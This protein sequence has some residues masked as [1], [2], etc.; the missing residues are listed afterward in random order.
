MGG[1][2]LQ[3]GW[4]KT[5]RLSTERTTNEGGGEVGHYSTE[6]KKINGKKKKEEEKKA[7]KRQLARDRL[8]QQSQLERE[9]LFQKCFER[10]DGRDECQL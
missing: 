3:D 9:R 1:E 2:P 5:L 6:G 10:T 7:A 8:R 4:P